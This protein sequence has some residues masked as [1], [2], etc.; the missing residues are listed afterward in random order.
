MSQDTVFIT[1]ASGFV[2]SWIVSRL[3]HHGYKVIGSV[4]SEEKGRVV[5]E[6]YPEHMFKHVIVTDMVNK[7]EFDTVFQENPQIKYVI[8]TANPTIMMSDDQIRDVVEPATKGIKALMQSA[9]EYGR[10]IEKFVYTGSIA[11]MT[12][13]INPLKAKP[14]HLYSEDVWSTLT[15]DDVDNRQSGAGYAVS[16]IMCEKFFW[17]FV[18]TEDVS[19]KATSVVLPFIIGIPVDLN[20]KP[21]NLGGSL[22]LEYS[23]YL[24]AS[25]FD[26]LSPDDGM[27]SLSL[28]ARDAGDFHVRALTAKSL[29]GKR[30]LPVE[31]QISQYDGA[32]CFK[33]LKENNEED[34]DF[35]KISGI[36]ML[37]DNTKT[38]QAIPDFEY[39][40]LKQS[41]KDFFEYVQKFES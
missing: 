9:K 33:A 29:D 8:H 14:D 22:P 28:D 23:W 3:I 32:R 20:T 7:F 35:K 39:I 17:S 18:E 41:L 34:C 6:L 40:P 30:A 11:S 2:A 31:G 15:I 12:P 25:K 4:R 10:N 19:F 36:R 37:Y 26:T 21:E 24:L 16:K 1:G 27:Y 13:Y 5:D 38:K